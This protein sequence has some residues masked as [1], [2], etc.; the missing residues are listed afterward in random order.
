MNRMFDRVVSVTVSKPISATEFFRTL[1]VTT[2]TAHRVRFR[3]EKK[4]EQDPN[5]CEITI[6]NLSEQTRA[7]FQTKPLQVRIDAGFDGNLQSLFVGD[8]IWGSSKREGTDWEL[9][10]QLG[11]GVR[12]I[13][14]GRTSL[15]FG[16]GVN[17]K[18]VLGH[19]AGT[20]GLK[21]PK[22]IADAKE[23]TAQFQ[24]GVTVHGPSRDQMSKLLRPHKMDWSIQDGRLQILRD[25]EAVAVEALLWN[26]STGMIGSPEFGP[27]EDE[28]GKKPKPPTLTSKSLL[29]PDVSPGRPIVVQSAAIEGLFRV[30]RVTHTG[31]THGVDWFTEIEATPQ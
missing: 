21:L 28:P 7:E 19:L 31:D 22:N 30:E 12:A 13:R 16:S 1:D 3:I 5:T 14:D 15:T 27:P 20:M 26:Q 24:T 11:D 9:K 18:T 6:S 8:L 23:L 10:L 2:I 25:G 29:R 4:I 17:A